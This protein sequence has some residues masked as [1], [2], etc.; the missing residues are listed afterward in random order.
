MCSGWVNSFLTIPTEQVDSM[1]YANG[2]YKPF[3][4][5]TNSDGGWE[6]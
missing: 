1:S 3:F 6:L 4:K 5:I 2:F